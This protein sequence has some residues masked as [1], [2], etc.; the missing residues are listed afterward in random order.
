M[1]SFSAPLVRRRVALSACLILAITLGA[2]VLAESTSESG[3]ESA[4]ETGA[5]LTR[6]ELQAPD[7]LREFLLRHFEL[8]A[9]PVDDAGR[10]ALIVRARAEIAELLAT[11]GYFSPEIEWRE[12]AAA[13]PAAI[14]VTPGAQTRVTR[15]DIEFA[16]ALAADAPEIAQR[17][18]AL[19]AAWRLKPGAVFRSPDWEAAKTALLAAVAD[20]DHAAARIVASQA[21]IDPVQSAATLSLTMDSGPAY[22]FG[23]L[24]IEGLKRYDASLVKG[25]APFAPGAPYRRNALLVFQSRLQNTPW[26]HSVLVEAAP[27]ADGGE[28]LPVRV[29]LAETPSKRFSFGAGYGTNTG[30]RGEVNFRNHDL[31]GRA[32]DLGSGLRHEQKRRTLFADLALLPDRD[33]YR[34]GFGAKLES[35]DIEGLTTERQVLGANRGRTRGRIETRLG[36]EWQR[37][38][39]RPLGAAAETDRALLLDWRWIHR[40]VDNSIDPR[41]GH[42]IEIGVGGASRRVLSTR[43]FVRSHLRVQQWW[44]LGRRDTLALRGEA[45]LTAALS[46]FGIPQDYLFRAGGAQS[47]R[48][49]DYQSLGVREGNAIVGGRALLTGSAEYIHWYSGPWGAALFVDAG[50]AADD[51]HALDPALGIGVGA[52]WKSPAGPLAF[53]LA[54]GQRTGR[55]NLHFSLSVAF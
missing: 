32:W 54:R 49:Y 22:R 15:V 43:D 30:A 38:E 46:R 35:T 4:T 47:V 36:V 27:S 20:E 29:V 41:D 50:D 5:R 34:L 16:G 3:G 28:L 42:L 6:V 21:E 24:A 7:A 31:F 26:F 8:P 51:W 52:R 23:E 53:D 2:P 1:K 19:R 13:E 45:G 33:D 11:E 12:L 14:V 25:L 9:A 48:G 37:E 17:R 40:A 10:Q 55:W 18:E 44:P 39:R